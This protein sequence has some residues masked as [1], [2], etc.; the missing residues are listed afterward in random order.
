MPSSNYLSF[1]RK[2]FHRNAR[3][4]LAS[5]VHWRPLLNGFGGF[6]PPNFDDIAT[7]AGTFPSVPGVAWLQELGVGYV[8]VHTDRYPDPIGFRRAL[9]LLDRRRDLALEV[10]DGSTRL[11]RVRNEK[12]RAIA[13]LRPA[14]VLSQLRFVDGPSE[15]SV[16]RAAGGMR[17]AFGFQSPER[18]I[19]YME[20][21]QPVPHVMLQ[22][23]V[24]MSGV[25]VDA[26]TGG[27]L[28]ELTVPASPAG[29]A[30]D[31]GACPPP[32]VQAYFST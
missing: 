25:L 17:R 3:Y 4:L 5:T 23:P 2:E 13:A 14:P 11:Y 22:L 16:L 18:F 29:R 10:T 20:S 27:V 8:V 24:A 21:T 9:D 19:A 1:G 6:A 26:V 31:T 30:A 28:R 32:D 15:G 12:A 7:R